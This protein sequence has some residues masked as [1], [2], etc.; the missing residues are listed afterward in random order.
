[1]PS[2]FEKECKVRYKLL[3]MAKSFE[4]RSCGNQ[5]LNRRVVLYLSLPQPKLKSKVF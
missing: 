3:I 5:N 4:I 2:L 1:M